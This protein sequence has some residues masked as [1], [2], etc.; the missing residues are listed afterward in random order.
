MRTLKLQTN[1]MNW[2]M[3][4]RTVCLVLLLILGQAVLLNHV[5]QH[6]LEHAFA[7]QEDNDGCSFCAIGGHMASNALPSPPAPTIVW[8]RVVYLPFATQCLTSHSLQTLG[9]RGPPFLSV[10]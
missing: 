9:A 5:V 7:Q 2:F 1:A 10:A 6:Q 4:W 3:R 8:A